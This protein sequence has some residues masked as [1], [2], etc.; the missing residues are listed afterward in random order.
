MISLL[1][2]LMTAEP[3]IREAPVPPVCAGPTFV[4]WRACAEAAQEGTPA[5]VLA[6][7]NL[8]T[9][10]YLAGDMAS[11]LDYYDKGETEGFSTTSDVVLHTFRADTRRYAGRMDEARADAR[12]AWGFLDGR[13]PTGTPDNLNQP[14]PTEMRGAILSIILPMLKDDDAAAFQRA[15]DQYMALPATDWQTLSQRAGVLTEL[16]EHEAAVAASKAA[17]DLKPQD[18]LTQNNHCYALVEA[19]RAAEALP[20]CERAVAAL[21]EIAPV[22]HSV[23]TVLAKLGRCADAEAQLVIARRLEPANSRYRETAVCTPKG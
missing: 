22:R 4:S 1:L 5:Y 21:P 10:A 8:G 6:M 15:R 23:A 14:I 11:A 9:E 19:G 2:A 18:G 16:G 13:P 3:Q 20:Y 17:L 7:I 12:L